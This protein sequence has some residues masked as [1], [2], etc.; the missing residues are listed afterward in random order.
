MH[1]DQLHIHDPRQIKKYW[2][3]H[4]SLQVCTPFSFG[5]NKYIQSDRGGECTSKQFTLLLTN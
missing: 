1:V 5:G 3:N 2:R 4:Q